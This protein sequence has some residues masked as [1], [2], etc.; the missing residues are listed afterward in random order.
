MYELFIEP[1]T[2]GFMQRGLLVTVLAALVC[3]LLSCWLVLMGW[4][5]MGDGISH[6]VLPGVALAYILGAPFALGALLA[7]LVAVALIGSVAARRRVRED[8]AIGIVFTVM[9]AL[10]LVLLSAFPS[11]VDLHSVIFGN[12][13]GVSW[14][15]VWQIGLLAVMVVAV[16]LVKRRD[17]V[18]YAFDPGYTHAIGL[19]PRL[20]SSLLLVALALTSVLA[21]Q[22]VGVVLVVALLVIPGA[23]ARLLT[24]R[25]TSMLLISS[26]VSLLAALAGFFLAYLLDI[27][28]G[29]TVVLALGVLFGLAY[30]F[31]PRHGLLAAA[32]AKRAVEAGQG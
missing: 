27:S 4:S 18:L 22:I 8:A 9:F 16:L 30:L 6:A 20:L 21:L 19:S 28:A 23:T 10:G 2:Y 32:R 15:D 25:F 11:Q 13:L 1:L 29:G 3:A 26:A 12:V 14:A 31:A 7:A 5:L 24:D 17:L